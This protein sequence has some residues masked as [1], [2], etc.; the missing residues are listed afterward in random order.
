M[1]PPAVGEV[2]MILGVI[3]GCLIVTYFTVAK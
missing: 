1:E 2:L 3:A